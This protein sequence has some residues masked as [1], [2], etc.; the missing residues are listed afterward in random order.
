MKIT[1]LKNRKKG[2]ASFY[3]T[4]YHKWYVGIKAAISG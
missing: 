4:I 1:K 3:D 2:V